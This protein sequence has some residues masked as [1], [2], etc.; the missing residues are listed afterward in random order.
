MYLIN[1]ATKLQ[2]QYNTQKCNLYPLH[3]VHSNLIYASY[4]Y[5]EFFSLLYMHR[6]LSVY[7]IQIV[8]CNW[9]YKI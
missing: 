4:N 2:F 5:K 3:Y 8:D 9:K 1:R 7:L 6:R